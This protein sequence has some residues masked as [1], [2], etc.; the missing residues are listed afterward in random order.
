MARMK[1]STNMDIQTL[2]AADT[3]P[4]IRTQSEFAELHRAVLIEADSGVENPDAH[5]RAARLIGLLALD[6]EEQGAAVDVTVVDTAI[7]YVL[8]A[9]RTPHDA[10][11][12]LDLARGWVRQLGMQRSVA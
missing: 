11:R 9:L 10:D 12:L 2:L 6:S 5:L 4:A 1:G 3:A 8:A 7:A